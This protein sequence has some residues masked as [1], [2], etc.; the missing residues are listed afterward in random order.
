MKDILIR[1]IKSFINIITFILTSF[2]LTGMI[3][4][5]ITARFFEYIYD[6]YDNNITE[7]LVLG[8]YVILAFLSI[9]VDFIFLFSFYLGYKINLNSEVSKLCL[10]TD[11]ASNIL[12]NQI[13]I[14]NNLFAYFIYEIAI[15]IEKESKED[16]DQNFFPDILKRVKEKNFNFKNSFK[17]IK[18]EYED[19]IG[20]RKYF[21]GLASF[22]LITI[23]NLTILNTN[24]K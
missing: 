10:S 22:L 19:A 1:I 2:L 23:I 8:I 15:K 7:N 13:M 3:I 11:S 18:E 17:N 5:A 24:I 9:I 14:R 16:L 21:I 6:E 20:D 12:G 4:W